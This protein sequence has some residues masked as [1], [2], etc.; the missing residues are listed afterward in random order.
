M[1]VRIAVNLSTEIW[2]EICW[3]SDPESG[4]ESGAVSGVSR[5]GAARG[6]ERSQIV[7]TGAP[8]RLQIDCASAASVGQWRPGCSMRGAVWWSCRA[9]VGVQAA[10]PNHLPPRQPANTLEPEP[11]APRPTPHAHQ[12]PNQ[13]HSGTRSV[14]PHSIDGTGFTPRLA[15]CRSCFPSPLPWPA[16]RPRALVAPVGREAVR[17]PG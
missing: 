14:Q 17:R 9:C 13:Y 4:A 2:C 11:T 7:L 10:D 5:G 12:R 16:G 1:G 8:S 3:Q 15:P 6:R